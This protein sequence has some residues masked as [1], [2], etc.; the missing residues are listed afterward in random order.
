MRV[1]EGETTYVVLAFSAVMRVSKEILANAVAI[2]LTI[3]T[4]GL[5]FAVFTG[6]PVFA[7]LLRH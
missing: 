3:V 1:E 7:L 5:T 2:S 6:L 4:L